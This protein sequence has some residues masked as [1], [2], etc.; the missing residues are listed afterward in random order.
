MVPGTTGSEHLELCC[1]VCPRVI[2]QLE[3][4]RSNQSSPF[5]ATL[6]Q[7]QPSPREPPRTPF[8]TPAV[9]FFRSRPP[10]PPQGLFFRRIWPNFYPAS[11]AE[12]SAPGSAWGR[13]RKGKWRETARNR[14]KPREAPAGPPCQRHNRF[15][16]LIASPSAS[17]YCS[18][19]GQANRRRVKSATRRS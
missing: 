16:V 9:H 10:A 12:P 3:L 8:L 14:G 13:R 19:A 7:L 6:E 17:H 4:A 18:A 11:Q 15:V 5:P 1:C 2:P